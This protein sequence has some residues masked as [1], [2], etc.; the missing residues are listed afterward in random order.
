MEDYMANYQEWVNNPVFDNETKKELENIKT[1]EE[2]IKERFYKNLEFGNLS[3]PSLKN[4]KT[5]L[6]GNKVCRNPDRKK[7]GSGFRRRV[8]GKE[9]IHLLCIKG[10]KRR[11]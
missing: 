10:K 8:T 2:E 9:Q 3:L 5:E 4:L 11:F 7:S 1:N 6:Y